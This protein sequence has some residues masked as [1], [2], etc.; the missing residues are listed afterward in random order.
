MKDYYTVKVTDT[1]GLFECALLTDSSFI[2]SKKI[3]PIKY[4]FIK[5]EGD[6]DNSPVWYHPKHWRVVK[7]KHDYWVGKY[8][9]KALSDD[10]EQWIEEFPFS[11]EGDI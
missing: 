5:L 1:I 9:F 2:I 7:G 8:K 3:D 10:A 4:G 6:K 11:F